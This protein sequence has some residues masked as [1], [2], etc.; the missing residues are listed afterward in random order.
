MDTGLKQRLM[1]ALVLIS[2]AVIFLPLV[3]DGQQERIQTELYEFPE[4]PVVT[5]QSTDFKPIKEEGRNVL[6]AVEE[7]NQ[8]KQ[9]QA[10]VGEPEIQ[11]DHPANPALA[12]PQADSEEPPFESEPLAEEPSDQSEPAQKLVEAKPA[13]TPQ[14]HARQHVEAEKKV[15]EQIQK[16]PDQDLKLADVW[17]IQVG[18]FSSQDNALA[19]R[20][21]LIAA[22]HKSYAKPLNGLVKVFVGPQI[23]KPMAEKEKAELE[24]EFGI[25]A[26]ILKYI[27]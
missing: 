22:G 11:S 8:Q 17:M 12:S 3:F 2:L 25:N 19:L 6:D 23:R 26:L 5:L 20:D 21:K 18:A 13:D 9:E 27:P 4:Q 14:E 15:D 7:I 16:N 10:Q 24:Q 1:G